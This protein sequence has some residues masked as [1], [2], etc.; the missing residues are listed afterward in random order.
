MSAKSRPEPDRDLVRVQFSV[1]RSWGWIFVGMLIGNVHEV[2]PLL[3]MLVKLL[4]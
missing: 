1:P 2:G 3:D 4:R